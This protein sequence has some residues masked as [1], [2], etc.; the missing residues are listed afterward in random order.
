MRATGVEKA[1]SEKTSEGSLLYRV[2]VSA[3]R[4]FIRGPDLKR[5]DNS[6]S[7]VGC[8]CRSGRIPV[9]VA[10]NACGTRT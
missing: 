5:H 4:D 3:A 10:H 9:H 1:E 8:E 6:L 7:R 2:G